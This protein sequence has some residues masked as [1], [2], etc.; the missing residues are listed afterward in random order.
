[1]KIHFIKMQALGNDF[2]VIDRRRQS[3][4][5]LP[6]ETCRRWAD[7]HLGI[8]ADQ[9]LLLNPAEDAEA[10]MEIYN[11]DGS[12][13]EACGNGTRCVAWWVMENAKTLGTTLR[14]GERLLKAQET[15][16][17]TVCVDMGTPEI[18]GE[19]SQ[20]VENTLE[21]KAMVIS[22]GNPHLVLWGRSFTQEVFNDLIGKIRNSSLFP[23]GINVD[24]V[25][26]RGYQQIEMIPYERGSGFTKAC[27]SGACAAAVTV[28][29]QGLCLSPVTVAM[30][31]GDV[32]IQYDSTVKLTGEVAFVFEGKIDY[33]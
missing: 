5:H 10:T 13:A 14:V 30:P 11:A 9:I 7:R 32:V 21:T 19:I 24:F 17:N 23:G 28:I 6:V 20:K 15:G 31:G 16:L 12:K 8:G 29:R 1:M 22:M 3:P 27:G 26:V 33:A 2:I 25:T 18:E 4:L